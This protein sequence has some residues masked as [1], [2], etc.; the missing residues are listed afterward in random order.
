MTLYIRPVHVGRRL[1]GT[2]LCLTKGEVLMDEQILQHFPLDV[3]G[4]DV[5]EIAVDMYGARSLD[6]VEWAGPIETKE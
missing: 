6:D 1:V 4:R 5:R 3:T 2:A